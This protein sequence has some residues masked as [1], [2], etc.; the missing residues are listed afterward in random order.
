MAEKIVQPDREGVDK[1]RRK[2]DHRDT[3][4]QRSYRRARRVNADRFGGRPAR[5]AGMRGRIGWK[6]EPRSIPGGSC[7]HP[8]P[9]ARAA[10]RRRRTEALGVLCVSVVRLLRALVDGTTDG[11]LQRKR[12][13]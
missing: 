4:T 12:K 8:I 5:R 11:I 7:F 1:A 3:E 6:H 9:D 10:T 2:L 13:A